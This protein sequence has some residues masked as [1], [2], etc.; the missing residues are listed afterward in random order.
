ME[1]KGEWIRI[2]K[3]MGL[4][5]VE[6]ARDSIPLQQPRDPGIVDFVAESRHQYQITS[7][8]SQ[9]END[10]HKPRIQPP[11]APR[12][13]W[14]KD[15]I[16]GVLTTSQ[17]YSPSVQLYS[18][19]PYSWPY[20]HTPLPKHSRVSRYLRQARRRNPWLWKCRLGFCPALNPWFRCFLQSE[21]AS[22]EV[23][24]FRDLRSPEF[25]SNEILGL[26]DLDNNVCRSKSWYM[27]S[28]EYAMWEWNSRKK[29]AGK[30]HFNQCYCRYPDLLEVNRTTVST[31]TTKNNR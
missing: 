21:R 8:R 1:V 2:R 14:T 31:T 28:V 24:A 20:T 27:R 5:G 29:D 16:T 15:A 23:S 9:D 19:N 25:E 17:W 6:G 12:R 30:Y 22:P 4:E 7:T 13:P 10:Y 26:C 3:G 18:L 11:K